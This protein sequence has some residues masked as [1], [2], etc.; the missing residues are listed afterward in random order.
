M[1]PS[2]ARWPSTPG[3]GVQGGLSQ[4]LACRE[5]CL[6][7][8]A[9]C[10]QGCP[11]FPEPGAWLC[12]GGWKNL[13]GR[14]LGITHPRAGRAGGAARWAEAGG[15]S[16]RGQQCNLLKTSEA[17]KPPSACPAPWAAWPSAEELVGGLGRVGR[18][19][20]CCTNGANK[21]K[22]G[23]WGGRRPDPAQPEG[24]AGSCLLLSPSLPC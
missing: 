24:L 8:G 2:P 10:F 3:M 18:S 9:P 11:G 6:L 23:L 20:S 7:Q 16:D 1:E 21:G 4:V 15:G 12:F 13:T 5:R 14:R 22:R 19:Q 17:A